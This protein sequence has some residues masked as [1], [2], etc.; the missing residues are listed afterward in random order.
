MGEW[1]QEYTH[2]LDYEKNEGL[3][4]AL[5]A[6]GAERGYGLDVEAGGM[7]RRRGTLTSM[8]G[9]GDIPYEYDEKLGVGGDYAEAELF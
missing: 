4:Q 6:S 9:E 2:D 3:A 7:R 8:S 5:E 1:E